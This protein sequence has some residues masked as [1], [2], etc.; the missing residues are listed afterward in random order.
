MNRF[1]P[2]EEIPA[3][4]RMICQ[5][6]TPARSTA[7]NLTFRPYLMTKVKQRM[8]MEARLPERNVARTHRRMMAI[9]FFER[10]EE[11]RIMA[12]A[13]N[14]EMAPSPF[15]LQN[16]RVWRPSKITLL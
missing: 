5:A 1:R 11:F 13:H 10:S 4:G 8:P 9:F 7:R 3:M 2:V 6:S 12:P 14:E 15:A 16:P